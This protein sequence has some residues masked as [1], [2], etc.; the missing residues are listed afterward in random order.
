MSTYERLLGL[1]REMLRD[2]YKDGLVR[3]ESTLDGD[4]G[5]SSLDILWMAIAIEH[6]FGVRLTGES[7]ADIKTIQDVCEFI[8]RNKAE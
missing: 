7:Y 2:Q 6:E 5:F 4:L 1:F 8:D 3:P